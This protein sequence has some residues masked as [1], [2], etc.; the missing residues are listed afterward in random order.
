MTK[1]KKPTADPEELTIQDPENI[2]GGF[3]WFF[4]T[5][6]IGEANFLPA[7]FL[8]M[9]LLGQRKD[10]K[11]ILPGTR[12]TPVQMAIM[13]SKNLAMLILDFYSFIEAES[14]KVAYDHYAAGD[15]T[16]ELA[17][18]LDYQTGV[19]NDLLAAIMENGGFREIVMNMVEKGELDFS[20]FNDTDDN[21]PG[22][23]LKYRLA[24]TPLPGFIGRI[25][26]LGKKA[27]K[28]ETLL[29]QHNRLI[30]E[31]IAERITE[32]LKDGITP[33]L[34]LTMAEE[35][36]GFY[37]T[38]K[39]AGGNYNPLLLTTY[40]NERTAGFVID[41]T[42]RKIFDLRQHCDEMR[43][44]LTPGIEVYNAFAD[45][46]RQGITT[47]EQD[48]ESDL[49]QSLFPD[50]YYFP[51]ADK[52]N[53]RNLP[54]SK[55]V[56]R[57]VRA[58]AAVNISGQSLDLKGRNGE[59]LQRVAFADATGKPSKEVI[60]SFDISIMNCVGSL[61][62]KN[63][64]KKF[65]TDI[66]I[67]KEFNSTTDKQGHIT[68]DSKIVQDIRQSMKRLSGVYGKI[69]VTEQISQELK[70]R[71]PNKKK[72]DNLQ[73]GLERL[74]IMQPLVKIDKIGVHTLKNDKDTLCYC[75]TEAPPFYLHGALTRQMVQVP[76][77]QL[78]SN[79][80]LTTEMRLLREYTRINI[81]AAISM[82]KEGL[83]ADT[84]RFNKILD[85][86][87]RTSADPAENVERTEI[88]QVV[89]KIP[90]RKRYRLQAY[91]LNYLDELKQHNFISDYK[92]VKKKL[93]GKTKVIEY[94]FTIITEQG[95]K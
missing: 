94:G 39:D 21:S 77:E 7:V 42:E 55:P 6:T 53:V 20:P 29:L 48:G 91:I 8:Y 84:I 31:E 9:Q 70:K 22:W 1:K 32:T 36:K 72:I 74:A 10:V 86:T 46:I 45:L 64:T 63:P 47:T 33:E 2:A 41:V 68:P 12:V 85:D 82:Q 81:E 44:L 34:L 27:T 71:H 40:T 25:S 23:F 52:K 30:K 89:Q 3:N 5:K 75:I 56:K 13:N 92:V 14:F 60:N 59:V 76:F 24:T 38:V 49:L 15:I 83:K 28:D 26:N 62:Q 17:E 65:F 73:K 80:S 19:N 93:P 51:P 67:A 88:T 50:T 16:P 18:I 87:Y 35:I 69:D 66:D 43:E 58:Y 90:E 61:Q 37:Q 57:L 54:V 79:K 78:T 95:G 4:D 11:E